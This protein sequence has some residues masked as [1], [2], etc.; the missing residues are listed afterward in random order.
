MRAGLVAA[1]LLLWGL[2][3]AIPAGADITATTAADVCPSAADPCEITQAV[4]IVSGSTLDFGTRTVNVGSGG[5]FDFGTGVGTVRCG[6]LTINVASAATGILLKGTISGV[7]IGGIANIET[8]RACSGDTSVPCLRDST[9]AALSAGTCSAGPLGSLTLTGKVAGGAVEPGIL[10]VISAGDITVNRPIV[11][12]GTTGD[13]DGGEVDLEST[14]GSIII[15]DNI[16]VTAGSF[17]V[18]GDVCLLAADDV[19]INKS[20][21]ATGGGGTG[22]A[23]GGTIEIEATN[24][25]ATVNDELLANAG[26]GF[27]GVISV[28]AGGNV[29]VSGGTSTDRMRLAVTAGSNSVGDSGDGGELELSADGNID[30]GEFVKIEGDGGLPDGDGAFGFDLSAGGDIIYRGI[31]E[32]RA[33]GSGGAGGEVDFDAGGMFL[34]PATG[35][36]DVTGGD[37]DGGFLTLSSAGDMELGGSIDAS[38]TSLGAGGLV[39]VDSLGQL[40]VNG[41]ILAGG[42]PTTGT[43]PINGD[44][45]LQACELFVQS[46]AVVNAG[47]GYGE[48]ELIGRDVIGVRSVTVE[49]GSQVLAQGTGGLNTVR[50]AQGGGAPLFSGTIDP[51]AT[52]TEDGTLPVCPGCG[53]AIVETG[54]TCDDGNMVGSD[55]CSAACQDE[56]CVNGTAPPG[57]PAVALCDD[58]NGCTVDTCDTVA[59]SCTHELSCDD[60][61]SCTVDTCVSMQCQHVPTDSLCDDSNVCTDGFCFANTG[62]TYVNNTAACDDELFCNGSVDSCLGGTCSVHSGN[63]CAGLPECQNT[64]EESTQGCIISPPTTSCT[65]D[66]NVCTDDLCDGSGSCTHTNNTAPCS[67]GIACTAGDQCS[68]GVCLA[69]TPNDSACD[70]GNICTDATCNP[71]I[72]CEVTNNTNPC[73]DGESCTVNDTCVDGMCVGDPQNCVIC[74]DGITVSPEECDD[75]SSNGV[76]GAPCTESCT[77]GTCGDP[78]HVGGVTASDA[79]FVLQAAVGSTSCDVCLCDVV[80]TGGAQPI[81][82][83]D[84]LAVLRRSVGVPVPFACPQC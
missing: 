18:G 83:S 5:M 78:N 79:L 41:S 68:G 77:L 76:P 64:C 75:G 58:G 30:V 69:G 52:V 26:A 7:G 17:S 73:N 31:L 33:K 32:A 82:A 4:H 37:G 71:Q 66:G 53:N 59:H 10:S 19:Q 8:R 6:N 84:A 38:A 27:G 13:S 44:I 42:T 61:I 15:N 72:G 36:I 29:V 50:Y 20:I 51:P 2:V 12:K 67:D 56:G 9:C 65:D 23:D 54:E 45:S 43:M 35:S 46:G 62:C 74:G 55:G 48:N 14:Q 47:G 21:D 11:V 34:L 1:A 28:V 57:Y 81:T 49:S 70:D 22:D 63:P 3:P 24:G 80:S 16:D 39:L 40:H 60:G 25:T